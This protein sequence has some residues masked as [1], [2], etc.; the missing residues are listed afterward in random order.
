MSVQTPFTHF[1]VALAWQSLSLV[2]SCVCCAVQATTQTGAAP[3][4]W[5]HELGAL[6]GLA[7]QATADAPAPLLPELPLPPGLPELELPLL[8]GAAP[9]PPL[10]V[11]ASEP[12]TL[13]P[14]LPPELEP[15][16]LP[17]AFD[18]VVPLP[19]PHAATDA[20]AKKPKRGVGPRFIE[21]LQG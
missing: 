9:P 15:P 3:A 18:G 4:D 7:P 8:P 2:H 12:A 17:P 5:Q 20:N 16:E 19:F 21:S 6:H 10:L 14:P 1:A 11:A 13:I